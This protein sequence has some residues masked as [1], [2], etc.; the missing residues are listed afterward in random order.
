MSIAPP[1]VVWEHVRFALAGKIWHPEQVDVSQMGGDFVFD[2]GGRLTLEYSSSS[3]DDRPSIQIV[4]AAFR[5]AAKTGAGP[6]EAQTRD[7][8]RRTDLGVD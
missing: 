1:H 6:A 7:L 8:P 2:R 4:M 3:S 5:E